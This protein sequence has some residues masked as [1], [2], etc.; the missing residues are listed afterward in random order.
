MPPG[1]SQKGRG[2]TF[3]PHVQSAG[4]PVVKLTDMTT[5]APATEFA[6]GASRRLR[7]GGAGRG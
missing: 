2:V 1:V 3:V 7:R 5:A 4:G 6:T